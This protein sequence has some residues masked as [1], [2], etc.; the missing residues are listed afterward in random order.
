MPNLRDEL[1]H[2]MKINWAYAHAPSSTVALYSMLQS[3]VPLN[4]LKRQARN[5]SADRPHSRWR[6]G[7]VLEQRSLPVGCLMTMRS[8][9]SG[10]VNNS[11]KFKILTD[12]LQYNGSRLRLNLFKFQSIIDVL[13]MRCWTG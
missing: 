5:S 12:S 7:M 6:T 1:K 9:V 11:T 13:L 4:V 3:A 2:G 10:A 8:A